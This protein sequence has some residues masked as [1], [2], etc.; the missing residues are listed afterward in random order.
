[1]KLLVNSENKLDFPPPCCI[2]EFILCT[3]APAKKAEMFEVAVLLP[4]FL[5]ALSVVA[6]HISVPLNHIFLDGNQTKF[7]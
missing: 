2:S 7:I 1:M 6:W 5:C 4:V 3:E